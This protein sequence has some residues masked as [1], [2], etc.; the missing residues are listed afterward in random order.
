MMMMISTLWLTYC[1]WQSILVSRTE[2]CC[3]EW[4]LRVRNTVLRELLKLLK[5]GGQWTGTNCGFTIKNNDGNSI[6]PRHKRTV[7]KCLSVCLCEFF[8]V[9]SCWVQN[10]CVS[11]HVNSWG[12]V[13]GRWIREW[14]PV[15]CPLIIQMLLWNSSV[16]NF[17][18]YVLWI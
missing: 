14:Q 2:P 6:P 8:T 1:E 11:K 15:C 13:N 3:L 16:N 9:S 18:F 4:G 17:T 5:Q 10:S 12:C 7:E